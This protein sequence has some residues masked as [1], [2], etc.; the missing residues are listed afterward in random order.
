LDATLRDENGNAVDPRIHDAAKKMVETGR[1]DAYAETYARS[2]F[3]VYTPAPGGPSNPYFSP[4]SNGVYIPEATAASS[5]L[6]ETLAHETFHA[7]ANA[8]G[9]TDSS[10]IEEGFGIAVI[11]YAFSDAPYSVA[12]AV[13]GTKNFYRDYRN[14]PGYPL[15]DMTDADPKLRELLGDVASR[16][17][18]QLAWD[19]PDQ[20]Q[21]DYFKYYE[22]YSRSADDDGNGT[23][24][25]SQPGGHAES[26]EAAM[27]DG[28]DDGRGLVDS[29]RFLW[30]KLWN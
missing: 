23:P 10:A 4:D 15:G 7:F 8:H 6:H 9:S 24:D 22:Q 17:Q 3:D 1:L 26:A 16:D 30:W 13:Y 18:S 20:L 29:F 11:D 2:S 14:N 19:D 21:W 28:R 27:L 5:T 25:W 12:E